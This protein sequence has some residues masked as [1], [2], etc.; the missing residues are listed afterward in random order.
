MTPLVSSLCQL[1]ST[2]YIEKAH[3]L[4]VTSIAESL[5]IAMT[6]TNILMDEKGVLFIPLNALTEL[7]V[8]EPPQESEQ[9][10]KTDTGLQSTPE[11]KTDNAATL[12]EKALARHY[13]SNN[14]SDSK[15]H[16][17]NSQAQVQPVSRVIKGEG[18]T[19][20]QQEGGGVTPTHQE[21]GVPA[22]THQEGGGPASTQQEQGGGPAST[23]QDG[24]GPAPTHQEGGGLAPTQQEQ[25]G[26]TP[27][28]QEGGG[29]AL[30]HQEGGG[31]A[32]THQDGGGPAP[33]YQDAGGPASTQQEQGGAAPTHQ[34]GGGLAPL[35][36]EQ[37][38]AT[39]TQQEGG[40]PAL[41]HQEGGGPAPTHQDGGGPASTY[42]DG[43]G[44]APTHQEGGGLAPTQQEQGGATH[45]QQ[46]GGGPA[47]TH[48]EGG[49][50]A[51]TQQE[52]G[53]AT[54]TQQEGGGATPTQQEEE[55]HMPSNLLT[56]SNQ[57]KSE[58]EYHN[59]SQDAAVTE[60]N[61]SDDCFK[62]VTNVTDVNA[63]ND[64]PPGVSSSESKSTDYSEHIGNK[65]RDET[66][67][68]TEET[69]IPKSPTI[70]NSEE[71]H[72]EKEMASLTLLEN[73]Q[74]QS[75]Q[76]SNV[77]Q[78]NVL[79]TPNSSQNK[80]TMILQ[81]TT[82]TDNL[83]AESLDEHST[84]GEPEFNSEHSNRMDQLYPL[85]K[86]K[87]DEDN[88]EHTAE[89]SIQKSKETVTATSERKRDETTVENSAHHQLPP[90]ESSKENKPPGEHKDV[91]LQ[92]TQI[93]RDAAQLY[94]EE[95]LV[96]EDAHPKQLNT[97]H[98]IPEDIRT[99]PTSTMYI[100]SQ[101]QSPEK[102]MSVT[103]QLTET[104][105]EKTLRNA[106]KDVVNPNT[107]VV[108]KEP[109]NHSN[110]EVSTKTQP[111]Q[112]I[113]TSAVNDPQKTF[114]R[115]APLEKGQN[116]Q[117]MEPPTY[118]ERPEFQEHLYME[119][120]DIQLVEDSNVRHQVGRLDH[121]SL[122]IAVTGMT[123]AGK[124]TF[125]NAIR[126]IDNDDKDAA[127]TGV[128]ETSMV[129]CPYPHPSMPNVNLWDLPG[130]GSPKFKAKK[131]L[132]DVKF[133][134]YDFFIII[135]SERFKENDMML[136]REILTK[137]KKFY[138]LRSKIDNEVRAEQYKKNFDEEKLLD[139]IRQDCINHLKKIVQ[140]I[141]FLISSLDLNKYDFP[142]LVETLSRDLPEYKKKALILFLP[143]YS[144]EALESKIKVFEGTALS[145][146]K[147]AA[148][149]SIAPIPGLAMACDAGILLAFF[150]KCYYAFG[151][152][153][154]SLD[155]LSERV[156]NHSLKKVRES[157]PLVMAVRKK[158]LS[159][160]ELSALSSRRAALE[161]AY[162]LVPVW[163]S[164][165]AASM[166]HSATLGL[167]TDGLKELA[168]TARE[169]LKTAR[170]DHI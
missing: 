124:S 127:P 51:P 19:L 73:T 123:G 111:Y 82:S 41:T 57:G 158:E 28:Q 13:S 162:S 10:I 14:Q 155:K 46:E 161:F 11:N 130:T 33:T 152:D 87:K 112:G 36:Q 86:M 6:E 80:S 150:I 134:M 78:D 118:S 113:N 60:P 167:L 43:G 61:G 75:Q 24:G 95:S 63:S 35:Q 76:M 85:R 94:S 122:N 132:K 163:G 137:K 114:P 26:A 58:Y 92:S 38:G 49:G 99:P 106:N 156:N 154:K 126:G 77:T 110:A 97:E 135:S 91:P 9:S 22:S 145:A 5:S 67:M 72:T 32:P 109:Q 53:G 23:H 65:Q 157:R 62:N 140:P 54:P 34:E 115:D 55:K 119:A 147:A 153:D 81:K 12:V 105:I 93:K 136:A 66:T 151:L 4:T 168:D 52:Q 142:L 79:K 166:S 143:I 45:T 120:D 18:A 83:R 121:V 47:L 139:Q 20:T 74:G 48:Q 25:G 146:A 149:I 160:R 164:R 170:I 107:A 27:T 102:K 144:T 69:R 125:I 56:L 96:N 128:T 29:P 70:S 71:M 131:Y 15:A 64:N 117:P 21:G 116:T 159:N 30:T 50:L 103:R 148:T 8:D 42:Q 169:V 100:K 165:R 89:R 37:G 138:F 2:Q 104:H 3:H 7:S 17:E 68:V 39:P 16:S 129:V 98:G 44:P 1:L 84:V 133:E 40:G 90:M 88:E 141:V 59:C 101:P 31:P 108:S